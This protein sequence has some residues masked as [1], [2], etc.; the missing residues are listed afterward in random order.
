MRNLAYA[1]K[2]L[3]HCIVVTKLS[4]DVHESDSLTTQEPHLQH[5]ILTLRLWWP[6]HGPVLRSLCALCSREPQTGT[7]Q[8]LF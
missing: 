4:C 3:E 5:L 1:C 2:F 7:R 8:E 6:G